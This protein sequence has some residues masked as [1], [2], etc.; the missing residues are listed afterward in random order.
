MYY[1]FQG[2]PNTTLSAPFFPPLHHIPHLSWCLPPEKDGP[3][4]EAFSTIAGWER[5]GHVLWWRNQFNLSSSKS[6]RDHHT[7]SVTLSS[8]RPP[9]FRSSH[10]PSYI[11]FGDTAGSS[12]TRQ[13]KTTPQFGK[14]PVQKS[15]GMRIFQQFISP[16]NHFSPSNELDTLIRFW[17]FSPPIMGHINRLFAVLWFF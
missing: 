4:V 11:H 12:S 16:S 17:F 6:Y 13:K 3:V 8:A 2:P 14:S 5:D 15:M 7:P 10:P 9:F 1:R